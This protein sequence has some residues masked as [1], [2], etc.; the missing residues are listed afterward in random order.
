MSTTTSAKRHFF[1]ITLLAIFVAI[2]VLIIVIAPAVR[3]IGSLETDITQIQE[4]LEKQYEKSQRLKR[5]VH[6]IDEVMAEIAPFELGL[7]DAGEE[8]KVI[9][10]LEFLRD[11][12]GITQ[13]LNVEFVSPNSPSFKPDNDLPAILRAVPYYKFS[14]L[15]HGSY[16]QQIHYLKALE[17]L[18]HYFLI[19]RLEWNRQGPDDSEVSLRFDA[20]LYTKLR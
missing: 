12:I 8:L 9:R 7:I 4:F 19:P 20:K 15:N 6:E 1:L 3:T 14:F 2:V 17:N 11:S 5:S 18:P 13:T 16:D 10:E